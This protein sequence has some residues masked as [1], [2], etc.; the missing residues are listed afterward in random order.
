MNAVLSRS[1]AYRVGLSKMEKEKPSADSLLESLSQGNMAVL[2]QL[3]DAHRDDFIRWAGQRF[4]IKNRDDLIDAWHDAM[5]MFYEQVRDKKLTHLT[6][7]VKTYLFLIGYRRLLKIFKKN[8]KIDLVD[9]FDANINMDESIN[10]LENEEVMEQQQHIL[11]LAVQELPAKS[12]QILVMRFLEGKS[13]PQIMEQ[14]GYTSE[15]AV[16][17]TISRGLKRLKELITERMA[18]PHR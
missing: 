16:S 14:T 3:Y 1:S 18:S 2:D 4:Y 15:N 10:V 6:C 5:I 12:R 11:H 8:E 7:D 9:A 17:V 13:I